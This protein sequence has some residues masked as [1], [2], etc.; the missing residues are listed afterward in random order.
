M[1]QA[2][3]KQLIERWQRDEAFRA[4][5]RTDPKR[6]ITDAGLELD[7]SEAAALADIDWKQT[8]QQLEKRL[9]AKGGC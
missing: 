5:V 4:A 8:D 7:P 3:L 9:T 2:K 1:D 6:A